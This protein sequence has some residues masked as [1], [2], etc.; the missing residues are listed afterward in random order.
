[1]KLLGYLLMIL[2][3]T[4]LIAVFFGY[5]HQLLMAFIGIAVGKTILSDDQDDVDNGKRAESR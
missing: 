1:M 4:A 2:G 3:V 5:T